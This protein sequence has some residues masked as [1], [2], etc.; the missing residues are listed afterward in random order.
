LISYIRGGS[1]SDPNCTD[2]NTATACTTWAA[3]P[4]FDVQHSKPAVVTY[5][6]SQNPPVQEVFYVQDNG[7]LTA[8]D[9]NTGKEQ[10]SFLIEEAIPQL[11]AMLASNNGP[12]IYVA[13][14]SPAIFYDDENGDGIINGSDRV[15]VFFGLRRGGRVIYALDI[16]SKDQP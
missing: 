1:T 4:H 13:D 7:M 10:W 9:A 16:T 14:G 8:V 15:W 2:G 6:G 5:D 3:W 11:S 12:E